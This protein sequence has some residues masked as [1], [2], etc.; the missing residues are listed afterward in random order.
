MMVPGERAAY[1][2]SVKTLNFILVVKVAKVV[3][4]VAHYKCCR[5]LSAV[6]VLGIINYRF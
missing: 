4:V 2:I 3:R 6:N 5:A 1:S